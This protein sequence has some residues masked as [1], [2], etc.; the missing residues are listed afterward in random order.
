MP[1]PEVH[2]TVDVAVSHTKELKEREQLR[3]FVVTELKIGC[4]HIEH[5]KLFVYIVCPSLSFIWSQ[6]VYWFVIFVPL[7]I[8]LFNNSARKA[9]N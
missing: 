4:D 7:K 2:S 8:L 9:I 3:L 5:F 6:T 1:R